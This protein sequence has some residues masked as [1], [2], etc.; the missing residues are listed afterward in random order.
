[1]PRERVWSREIGED[2]EGSLVA[3]AFETGSV[4]IGHEPVEEGIAIGLVGK[5]SVSDAPLWLVADGFG[6]ASVEAFD[7]TVGLRPVRPGQAMVDL[8]GCA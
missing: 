5:G 2:F 6:D 4:V 8:L 3:E 7:E 1:M